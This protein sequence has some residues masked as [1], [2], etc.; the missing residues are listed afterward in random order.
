MQGDAPPTPP[1]GHRGA[2]VPQEGPNRGQAGPG[3]PGGEG[4]RR[5]GSPAP[6]GGYLHLGRR[7]ERRLGSGQV[8]MPQGRAAVEGPRRQRNAQGLEDWRARAL[9]PGGRGIGRRGA[10]PAPRGSPHHEGRPAQR[11]GL[12]FLESLLQKEPSEVAITLASSPSLKEA[13]APT[14]MR[15]CFLQALCQALR[16][17]CSSRID[18]RSIQQLMGAVKDSNFLKICLPRYV[19]NMLTEATPAVRHQYPEH[20]DNI[21]VLV[22][23]MASVFP[24]SSIQNVS[25]LMS[26]LPAAVNALRAS[27][28]DFAPETES[29]LE[30]VQA[31]IGHLQE[32][33]REG[34]LKADSCTLVHP[35]APGEEAA[36]YRTLSIYPTYQEVHGDEK[37][38]LRPNIISQQYESPAVY[39]DT[40]FRLLRE[41]FVRPLREGILQLLQSVEDRGL[42]GKRF[43]DI[44]V[45]FDVR[46]LSPLCSATG[47][48]HKV[49]FDTK[50]LRLVRWENS[51]RLLYGSLVCLSKDHFESFLFATVSHR[52]SQDL[53]KGVVHLSFNKHSRALLADVGPADSFLMVETTAYFEAYRHV[54]KGLQELREEEIPFQDYIVKCEP[55]VRAP[56]YLE[57][58]SRYDLRPLMTAA[59]A[60]DG[61]NNCRD[62]LAGSRVDILDPD[63]WPALDLLGL[64]AS[65]MEA[66]RLA[67]TKELAII[68]GP[69]G[70]GK[71]YV[72]LKIVRAL[73][74]NKAQRGKSPILVVCYTNHALDQFLEGIYTF[75]KSGIVR[76]GGRSSSESLRQFTLR[77]LRNRFRHKL[78]FRLRQAYH[79]ISIEMRISQE[80]LQESAASLECSGCGIL[81]DS[82]LRSYMAKPHW[83]SLMRGWEEGW[84]PEGTSLLVEWLGLGLA[85]FAGSDEEQ[86]N[87]EEDAAGP[88]QEGEPDLLAIAEEADLIQD[89]RLL[90]SDEVA[91]PHFLK[92]KPPHRQGATA[93]LADVL[94]A[95]KLEEEE[96]QGKGKPPRELLGNGGWEVQRGQKKKVK[97]KVKRELRKQE[98][99]TEAQ[100]EAVHDVWRLDRGSRWQ[101]YRHWLQKYQAEIR[102]SILEDEESYQA[103]AERLA[104]LRLH[105]DLAILE[106]AQIIGMTTTGAARYRQGLQKVAP[107][108]V[109]VEEAAEVLEAH[110]L[111]TLSKA[112][113]HLI[114]I[115][116]HQQLRPSANVYDLAKNFNLEVSLFERL[117]KVGLPFVRLDFQHRMRPEIA[118]LLTPHIYQELANHPSVLQY[119]NIKGVSSNLFFVEHQ[120]PEQEI[121]EGRSHQNLHEARF[122]VELC[123][124]L[125][126]QGYLPSQ[127]TIL[128]TYTGQL[129]CL[130]KLLPAKA[131]QGVKVHV[132]DKYQGEENDIVLLSLVRSNP[133]GRVGFLQIPNRVCVALSRAKKGLYCIG[134][135]AMLSQVPLW[136]KILHTLREKG[137]IG[138]SLLLC[139]Q[140]H[141]DTR[142]AVACAADFSK[143]PEGGCSLPCEYRLSCGH[144]CPRACHPYDLQHK[145]VQCVK[146]CQRR[147]CANGHRCPKLCSEPCGKC[148]VLM[149][150]VL[151]KCGH[152]QQVPCSTRAEEFCCQAPCEK[153]LRCGHPC[154]ETCGQGCTRRCP[155]MV[156]VTL[157]CGHSQQVTCCTAADMESGKPVPCQEKCLS[158]LECGHPC[159]GSCHSCFSGRFHEQCRRPCKRLLICSHPCKQ[160]CTSKCPPCQRP[161]E[162]R[163]GHSLCPKTCGEPCTPCAE[164]CE[165]RCQHYQCTKLCSEPCDRPRCDVPCPKQLPCGHTCAG[166]CG[167]PCPSKC[168][169]CDREELTQ[170]FFGFEDEP[171]ARF[172]Q[173]EDCKHVF[174]VTGLDCY[175]DEGGGDAIRLK[176]CP[177]CQTPIRKNLRYGML[178]RRSLQEVE[179]VKERI[180]GSPGEVAATHRRLEVKLKAGA[181]ALE[182]HLP[183]QYQQLLEKLEQPSLS[184]QRLEV[185]ENQVG[186]F[187]RLA[188]L[189]ASLSK[190]DPREQEGVRR[191]LVEVAQWLEGPHLTLTPQQLLDLQAEMQRLAF[192]LDLLGACSAAARWKPLE[193]PTAELI[194]SVRRVLEAAGRFT[195][196]DERFV[197]EKMEAVK[198]ALPKSGLGISEAERVQIVTAVMTNRQGHWFKCQNGHIYVITECGGAMEEG[199]CPECQEVIGGTNHRLDPSNRLAPE[200]DGATHAAWSEAANLLLRG[201]ERHGFL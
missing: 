192:L 101:L 57:T 51:K 153:T 106:E 82:H 92:Q 70:T 108:V 88:Q 145:E 113:Q 161:C 28:V 14:A 155:E 134:N 58:E 30:K 66:L 159:P 31:F 65:Q 194:A 114:L 54:L 136:S 8:V 26:A 195:P 55:L 85:P 39:L 41:D 116:D 42:R 120:F 190:L 27:G 15:P 97:E 13:L 171:G 63:Q 21:V 22:Q 94:L 60:A 11:I 179:S 4:W 146:D 177:T 10:P 105:E 118:H 166:M 52:D 86:P 45:Y 7:E 150:R 191:R 199:R 182:Q 23:E 176:V 111:T 112:C 73:L 83:E 59:P 2:N 147:L 169:Q 184:H 109:V 132:V 139:C 89:E 181:R 183:Q 9:L 174:E 80:D 3:H 6:P 117:V 62:A 172:V 12:Q 61:G 43:D 144:V 119:D 72:G 137:H 32:K 142:T 102:R 20:I 46:I 196:E 33:R 197:K 44:R 160:P 167:E 140:N 107:C 170:I 47:I 18:R 131:F 129:F 165:W 100:A 201:A 138:R 152:L 24:A 25:V 110:T 198:A 98:A 19:A 187:L 5:R 133:A 69:P 163:C 123:Q 149:P 91:A 168:L 185:L 67:L 122:V 40:Q 135:M 121:Q 34:T 173:L 124:Y 68:Q 78:P 148:L 193:E 180:W 93:G 141:P 95:L 1:A 71:T 87:G 175:M 186:F 74:R 17:A 64:D 81:H 128:T 76:V 16:T 36:A 143:A 156:P 84:L 90:D 48:D 127:L 157:A 37:P 125:L 35:L 77:E 29:R 178:V 158:M 200:M 99:M 56:S 130:R 154:R 189:H 162:N 104:E 96:E 75:Q 79:E 126:R 164:P 49:Q 53:R 38:F 103:A 188:E 50:S 115:G 151:P